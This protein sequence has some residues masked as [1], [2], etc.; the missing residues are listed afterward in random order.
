[1]PAK[2]K[3]YPSLISLKQELQI[4][5]STG[6]GKPVIDFTLKDASGKT[7]SLSDFK[8][9]YVFLDFWASWC[10]PCRKENPNVKAQYEKYKNKDFTVLS[11]SMDK[12]EAR[13]AWTEAIEKDGIG[14]W[15]H[16]I[17]EA[18]FAGTVAKSYYI[19][20]I[21]TNFLISPEGKFLGRN[22]YGE[23]LDQALEKIFT[24]K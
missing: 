11:V 13:K 20:S 17:D 21:P 10:I 19:T 3:S 5:K 18:G 6:I 1:L 15:T 12:A 7:V 14:M 24:G 4:S 9:K 22:L 2:Y 8:G 23:K 16:L